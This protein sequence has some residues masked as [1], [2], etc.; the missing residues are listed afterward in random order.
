ME[1][2]LNLCLFN[3]ERET[4]TTQTNSLS[5]EMKTYYDAR[6]IDNAVP[7]LVHD[8][9]AQKR[10]IPMGGG[11]RIMFRK[12]SPLPKALK[13]LAEGKTPAGSR[14]TVTK[15]EADINQ[16]GDFIELS[17]VLELT[18]VDS[19]IEEATRLLGV[20]AGRTLDTITREQITAGHQKAFAPY[21]DGGNNEVAV[22]AREEVNSKCLLTPKLIR[23]AAADLKRNNA[24]PVDDAYVAIIHPDVACDLQSNEEWIESHKYATPENIYDGE[25]GKIAGVRFVETTE[26]K[27]IGP[28]WI[29][30]GTDANGVCRLTVDAVTEESGAHYIAVQET[31]LPD[32][33]AEFN[34]QYGGDNQSGLKV[35]VDGNEVTVKKVTEA[36]K[37]MVSEG[38][39]TIA[40]VGSG[41]LMCGTGAG[42]D[43]T[44]I[45]CTMVIGA[46]AY[47]VTEVE[48]GGLENIIKQLG[49][50]GTSD[51]LNQRSTTGW[52]ALKTCCRLEE[53]YMTRIE[54][55]S[56]TF[57]KEATSN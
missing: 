36:G 54:H 40:S 16:Y 55:A 46:N 2:K 48:G 11:N 32:Q 19:N 27:I 51:P 57:S 10:P 45:Y 9:F 47:G 20:Q 56:E 38:G 23:K 31:V 50:A 8:Q 24:M 44:A 49:S 6:L 7:N 22:L 26:A 34:N 18:A 41:A 12:F 52:K 25:I 39:S 42:K 17:D 43:G 21:K 14:L 29:F 4:M 33:I 1:Y 3:D 28:N 30:G 53:S 35:Y 15:V 5:D 13:T 37:F